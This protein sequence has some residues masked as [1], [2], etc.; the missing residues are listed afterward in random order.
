MSGLD[1][2]TERTKINAFGITAFFLALATSLPELFVAITAAMR[3]N[4]EISVG[5]VLGSNIANLSI[6][7]GGAALISGSVKAYDKFIDGEVFHTFLAGS[8][9]LLL[10]IDGS[11]TRF[12][13][14]ILLV[15]YLLYNMTVLQEKRKKMADREKREAV[16]WKR[17]WA[18]ISDRNVERSMGKMVIGVALL[19]FS[20]DMLVRLAEQVAIRMDLPMVLV[21]L[22]LVAL[23]TSL[24]ELSFEIV[25]LRKNEAEMAL[26]NILGSVVANSTLILGVTVMI[27]PLVLHDGLKSYLLATL[28]FIFV[29]VFFWLFVRTKQRLD[30][31]EGLVLVIIYWV[32]VIFEFAK[33]QNGHLLV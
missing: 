13:G 27:Q 31:W 30:R 20:A 5:N 4:P 25:A 9:P 12:D 21:G 33:V 26:G 23:G 7:L 2:I 19:I 32:F 18:Q 15:V 3:G 29:F 10:L 11:L 28:A 24:P 17:W 16:W 6:V 22:I 1:E 8:L 14:L